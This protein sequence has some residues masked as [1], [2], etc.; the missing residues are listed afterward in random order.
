MSDLDRALRDLLTDER[1]DLPARPDAVRIVHDGVRRRRRR[2]AIA[3]STIAATTIGAIVAAALVVPAA[4]TADKSHSPTPVQPDQRFDV[5]W[6]NKP[7]PDEPWSPKPVQPKPPTMD[8]PRCLASQLRPG[9]AT[10]N[11]GGG[12]QFTTIRLRNVSDSPCLLVGTPPRVA[13]QSPGQPDVVATRGLSLGSGG[14]GGDLQPG[15]LGYLTV[16]TYRDCAAADTYSSLSV[17]LPSGTSMNVP[18]T[19]DAEC[20]LKTGGL[21]VEQPPPTTPVDPRTYLVPT[22]EAPAS[23]RPGQVLTYVVTLTNPTDSAISLSHCPGYVSTLGPSKEVLGL[24]CDGVRSIGPGES[25]RYEMRLDV[26][27]DE[28]PGAH[29]LTWVLLLNDKTPL[30]STT[31]LVQRP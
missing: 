1:L 17:T 6:V 24:N 12:V 11:A 16:Q 5:A 10:T 19:L 9:K 15:K 20:G 23:A 31:V 27:A 28:P 4:L 14:V 3:V 13:A 2:R 25:V 18:L 29:P 7:A 26:I 8:A 22:I 21:G 30:V